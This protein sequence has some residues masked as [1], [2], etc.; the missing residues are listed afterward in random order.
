MALLFASPAGATTTST[1]SYRLDGAAAKA[2][3]PPTR[4][5]VQAVLDMATPTRKLSI[6]QGSGNLDV[7]STLW[8]HGNTY[9][10]GEG[11]GISTI[12]RTRFN[13]ADPRYH[14]DVMNSARWAMHTP[15]LGLKGN[16]PTDS[17]ANITIT[18]ITID[19]NYT[20]WPSADPN[21]CNN[22]GIQ[23]WFSENV[24]IRDIEI[25]NTL[26]T[27]IEFD[28][29]RKVQISDF[30]IHDVGKQRNVGTRNGVN[31]NNNSTNLVASSRWGRDMRVSGGRIDN[32]RDTMLDCANVSDVMISDIRSYCDFDSVGNLPGQAGND[33]IVGLMGIADR[34]YVTI[35]LSNVTSAVASGGSG[36]LDRER[37]SH[38][39]DS[40]RRPI[41]L[42]A[43][44]P[45]P[46]APSR[47]P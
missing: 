1:F 40:R 21:S 25:K 23:L 8:I 37:R 44:R 43:L 19:G 26:Q 38:D 13:V 20:A 39:L 11:K 7:D 34:T 28:A 5:N 33:V 35:S 4:A 15:N 29:C 31:L 3:N 27:A 16:V 42:K 46:C 22:F 32:H 12:T 41:A 2:I 47:C 14:G 45:P 18:G 17:L 24:A 6:Q 30:Y 10:S 9:W 36:N